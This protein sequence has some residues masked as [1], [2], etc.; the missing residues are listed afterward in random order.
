VASAV[1]RLSPS[2]DLDDASR[3]VEG[4]LDRLRSS[5]DGRVWSEIEELVRA[6][7]DLYG[8]GLARAVEVGGPMVL[9]ELA[10]DELVSSLLVLHGLHPD[11]LDAR[12]RCAV[13]SLST[14]VRSHGGRV[15]EVD[16]DPDAGIVRVSV[17]AAGGAYGST[18]EPIRALLENALAE[19]LPDAVAVHV[20]VMLDHGPAE[21]PV[22][23]TRKPTGAGAGP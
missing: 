3:R 1:R 6:L 16:V 2:V 5:T 15:E 18:G 17:R 11:D 9:A 19:T 14:T 22:R 7:T 4:L 13:E 8:A 23:L 21:R 10:S 20:D 12:A